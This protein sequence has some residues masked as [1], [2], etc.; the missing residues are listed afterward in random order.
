[1]TTSPAAV[2]TP[3]AARTFWRFWFASTVSRTGS[4]M[5]SVALP[6][7][8]LTGLHATTF[9]VTLLAAATQAAW[10]FLGLPAGVIVQRFPLRTTQVT[11]DLIR[12]VAMGSVPV[13]WWLDRLTFPHLLLTALIT[14]LATVL[15]DI[16]N[17]TFL[18]A[19]V[20]KDELAARNSLISGTEAVSQTGAPS[21]GGLLIKAVGAANVLLIDSVSYLLSALTL[22][23]LPERR[24]TAGTH[25][26][27]WRL[28]R[29]GCA[30][31][32]RHP[33]MRPCMFWATASNFCTAALLALTPLYLVREA[34]ASA[35]VVGLVLAAD[36]L[37]SLI[38]SL[39]ATRLAARLGTARAM[40]VAGF[41]GGA[42][43]LVMPLTTTPDNVH[44]FVIGNAGAA[45]AVVIGSIITRTHRQVESPPELLSRVMAT[46]R[47]ISWGVLPL[48][49]L[50]SGVLADA[51]GLRAALWIVC[52][53]FV[54][55]PFVLVMSPVRNRRNLSEES[56]G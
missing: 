41:A 45:M 53:G 20:S 10:L 1:M 15:F 35:T 14:S 4:N 49:A 31:V 27:A 32:V 38:G 19:L 30:F 12:A 23:T 37:G 29:E 3:T 13:A 22:W 33:V 48:G 2:R 24:P 5:T 9:Q 50:V 7:V 47:F 42:L 43:A 40:I 11:M 18:P 46:V 6:L 54:F 17:S 34:G 55:T 36:G 21:L 26:S 8:A 25:E 16:G 28:I 56:H 51:F 52:A 44:F 39:L